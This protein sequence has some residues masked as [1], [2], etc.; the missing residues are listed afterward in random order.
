MEITRVKRI[1]WLDIARTV[2]IIS[3]TFNHAVNR[4]FNTSK[5]QYEEYLS[6]PLWLTIIKTII[7]AFSRLGVP[8]FLMISGALLLN[9][10]YEKEGAVARFLKHNWLQLFITMLI[11]YFIYFWFLQLM[12]TSV[13]RSQGLRD[14]ILRFVSTL[15]LINPVSLTSM[16]Y[17]P[18]IVCVYLM[19]PIVAVAL[20]R[21]DNRY[22]IVPMIIVLISGFIFY[23][24]NGIVHTASNS[25]LLR[26]IAD[27]GTLSFKLAA[28]NVFSVYLVY[29]LIGYFITHRNL[30]NKTHTALIISAFLVSFLAFGA[31]QFWC[32]SQENDFLVG[33]SYKSIA[34]FVPS[35]FL[36][37]LLRRIKTEGTFSNACTYIAR[38][39]LGIYFVHIII[40]RILSILINRFTPNIQHL[41]KF[42]LLEVVSFLGAIAIIAVLGRIKWIRKNLFIIK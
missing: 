18:M 24:L 26:S 22:F 23:D 7:Y 35:V 17:M 16:W 27:Q 8:L 3:I 31:F 42:T 1:N 9:K 25:K 28:E 40:M 10:D 41:A 5:M 2:A 15:L 37:E 12:P 20:K 30:L 39:S 6:M 19:I 4:S 32:Y 11:W 34:V 14:C 36:F 38:I 21:I 13:L 29:I 33:Q